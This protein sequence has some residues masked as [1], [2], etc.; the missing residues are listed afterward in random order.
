MI[1]SLITLWSD[2]VICK[3][4]QSFDLEAS[5]VAWHMVTFHKYSI[6]VKKNINF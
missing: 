3:N 1:Y 6:M 4:D 2:N 5:F